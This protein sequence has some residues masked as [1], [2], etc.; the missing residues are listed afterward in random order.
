MKVKLD[1]INEVCD[2]L[3]EYS[4]LVYLRTVRMR[5][6]ELKEMTEDEQDTTG[7]VQLGL[8]VTAVIKAPDGDWLLEFGEPCGEYYENDPKEDRKEVLDR[9]KKWRSLVAETCERCDLKLRPGKWETW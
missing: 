1:D 2:E 3:R 4:D 9:L 7:T 5:T 6:H 8:W